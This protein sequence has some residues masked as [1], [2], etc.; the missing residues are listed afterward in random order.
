MKVGIP[1]ALLFHFYRDLW[2]DFFA[3]LGVEVLISPE[4]NRQI[5]NLGR[6]N[7]IDEACYSSKIYIG[8]V[9]WL[10]GKCDVIF[11]PRMEN[12][13]IKEDFC[14]R[15]IGL[16]DLVKNTFPD[17]PLLH[18]DT[19]YLFRKRE[20]DAYVKIGEQLGK[21]REE[22]LAAYAHALA[23]HNAAKEA[24]IVAQEQLL[25]QN[26]IA[27]VLLVSHAYNTFDA[28]V[29][30]TIIDYFKKSGVHVLYADL[31]RTDTHKEKIKSKYGSR[32]YWRVN[33]ELFSGIE[34]Y[35]EYVDG[36]VLVSTFPCGPDSIFN[37]MIIR[38]VGDK[39]IL[40]I[41]VDELEA[42]AG[43]LTRLESF[44]D[45]L[46]ARRGVR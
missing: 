3:Q 6:A 31:I 8:H 26:A 4:T 7:C 45:I 44:V 20:Q 18:A 29:G 19:N 1:R 5:I 25:K 24:A 46:E 32:M 23:A 14:T 10:V 30:R 13:A 16:Y 2:T 28:A 39:P 43:L 40:N 22:S 33:A 21:S 15:I 41:M 35:R 34:H 17:A 37:E 27:K 12:T 11:V 38:G 9:A 36:L 42:T